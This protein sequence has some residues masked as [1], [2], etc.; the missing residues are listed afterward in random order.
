MP[1]TKSLEEGVLSLFKRSCR[2][3]R[4]DVAEHLLQALEQLGRQGRSERL[5]DAYLAISTVPAKTRP[6]KRWTH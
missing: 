6:R 1:E 5:E 3:G 4:L 2:E